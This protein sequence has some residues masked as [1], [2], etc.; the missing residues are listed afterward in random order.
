MEMSDLKNKSSRELAELL[1]AERKSLHALQ[2]EARTRAL[3]QVHKISVSRRT[4]ARL[5]TVKRSV[6][7]S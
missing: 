3:K 6:K 7:T 5:E 2:L 4:I 1:A